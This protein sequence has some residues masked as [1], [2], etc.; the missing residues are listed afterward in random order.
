MKIEVPKTQIK[1]FEC[2]RFV[3]RA[4]ATES[5]R[6]ALAAVKVE[7]DRFIACD[8]RRLHIADIK[9]EYDEGLYEVI[10]CNMT[11]VVLLRLDDQGVFP[12][13]QDIIPEHKNHFETNCYS[14]HL[15]PADVVVFGLARKEIIVRPYHLHD[16]LSNDKWDIFF[17]K[18]DDAILCVHENKRAVIMS[19]SAPTIKYLP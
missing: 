8:G 18:P 3:C 10:K 5:T 19:V 11:S 17:G 1:M 2:L 4:R 6:Y 16:A 13:Y 12:K 9:H 7:K 14:A 15:T